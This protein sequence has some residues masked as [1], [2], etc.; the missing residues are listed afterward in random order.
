MQL[1]QKTK[2]EKSLPPET[3]AIGL[4]SVN[5]KS[6]RSLLIEKRR[7][8]A[9]LLMKQH[10][11]IIGDQL[12][13]ACD[14][15][16]RIYLKLSENSVSIEQVFETREWIETLPTVLEKQSEIVRRLIMVNEI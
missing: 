7:E 2:L 14:E 1:K 6:L 4:F 11:S 15:Y 5:T 10:A 3:I 8:L 16:K 12:E 13:S 9:T